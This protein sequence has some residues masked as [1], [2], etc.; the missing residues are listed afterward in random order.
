MGKE[1]P[2]ARRRA[3][4]DCESERVWMVLFVDGLLLRGAL[5]GARARVCLRPGTGNCPGWWMWMWMLLMERA[6]AHYSGLLL[7]RVWTPGCLL[8]G[9]QGSPKARRRESECDELEKIGI[10]RSNNNNNKQQQVGR[11]RRKREEKRAADRADA[12]R[13]GGYM[14]GGGGGRGRRMVSCP[15]VSFAGTGGETEN[16]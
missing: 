2:P 7:L 4:V 8:L 16:R 11:G 3:R 10:C 5:P 12:A 13:V 6:A 15:C 14:R 9:R 1:N